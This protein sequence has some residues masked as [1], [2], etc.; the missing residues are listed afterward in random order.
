MRV[1]KT[2]ALAAIVLALAV[3]V[4]AQQVDI[5]ATPPPPDR[6]G[7]FVAP[8]PYYDVTRPREN[9]WYPDGVRVP[10]DPAFIAPL[11]EEYETPTSR[12]RYGLAGWTSQN[13]PVGAP[14]TMYREQ[15]GWLS[16]GFA[17]TWGAPPRPAAPP[18][19]APAV[20]PAPAPGR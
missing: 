11:S 16:F 19:A 18:R 10:Y 1:M 5:R 15:A 17:F 2:L 20:K 9:E 7:E 14:G 3:P 4:F 8:G 6:P 13:L 12:G